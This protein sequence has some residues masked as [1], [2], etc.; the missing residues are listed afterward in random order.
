MA[1]DTVFFSSDLLT[2]VVNLFDWPVQPIQPIIPFS[3]V[4]STIATL[5]RW[6]TLQDNLSLGQK[7]CVIS[8][9]EIKTWFR[10]LL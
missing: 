1:V 7:G 3:C 6:I 2:R 10:R 5:Y 9:D 8:R 4:T